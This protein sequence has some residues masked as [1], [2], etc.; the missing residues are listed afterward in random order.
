MPVSGK[1]HFQCNIGGDDADDVLIDINIA[2]L[3][4]FL[5]LFPPYAIA[6]CV[7]LF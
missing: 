1:R 7:Q 3:S 4:P 2:L 6:G 5:E